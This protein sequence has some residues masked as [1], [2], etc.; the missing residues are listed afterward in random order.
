MPAASFC[1]IMERLAGYAAGA[2]TE[3]RDILDW[4]EILITVPSEWTDTAGAIANMTVPYGIY[5]EDYSDLEQGAREIAHIDLIDE[6]LLAKNREE[7]VIHIYLSPEAN[8]AEAL[9][10]LQE[11][12]TA[13]GIPFELSTGSVKESDWADNWKQFFKVT[14]VGRRLVIRP[15]WEEYPAGGERTVLSIDPGAAF[16]TGTHATTR[17]CLELLEKY[18]RDGDRMLDIGCGSGILSI[19]ALLLGAGRAVGVDI[20]PLAVKVAGENAALN[21]VDDRAEYFC[22]N[23]ADR[24]EGTYNVIC[25]NIVADVV[26]AL[27]PDAGR[28]LAEDGVFICSGVIDLRG[29]EVERCL[30]QNGFAVVDT[31]ER[32]NWRAYAARKA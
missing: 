24:V 16:G 8:A 30:I 9:S 32:E 28:F 27:T 4:F 6:E 23:L 3:R 17:I 21:R 15:T 12:L 5:I 13:A 10:F 18:I 22:G 2:E 25:A 7:S 1:I 29:D 11:R 14:E 19:A 20:D 31:V 26:M